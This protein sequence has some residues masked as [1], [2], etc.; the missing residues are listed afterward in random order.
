M[1]NFPFVVSY[2]FKK[3]QMLG[4]HFKF[5]LIIF[6]LLSEEGV[7]PIKERTGLPCSAF[8]NVEINKRERV[9]ILLLAPMR[10]AAVALERWAQ[11]SRLPVGR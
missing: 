11:G 1:W 3:L 7:L 5:I 9:S 2:S 8:T 6:S 10:Q 4:E